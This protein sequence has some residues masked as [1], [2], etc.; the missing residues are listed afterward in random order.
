LLLQADAVVVAE[1]IG[2]VPA[3]TP[4]GEPM[5]RYRVMRSLVGPLKAGEDVIVP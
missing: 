4:D 5:A 3:A 2:E 1:R